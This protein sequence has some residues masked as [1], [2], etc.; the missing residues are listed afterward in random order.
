M[1]ASRKS[2]AVAGA[3]TNMSV[4]EKRIEPFDS[5]GGWAVEAPIARDVDVVVIENAAQACSGM[6]PAQVPL[7]PGAVDALGFVFRRKAHRSRRQSGDRRQDDRRHRRRSNEDLVRTSIPRRPVS[8]VAATS[9]VN[10]TSVRFG[11]LRRF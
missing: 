9:I 1:P 2:E 11:T 8:A 4:G 6:S 10:L 5:Q 7:L 3:S